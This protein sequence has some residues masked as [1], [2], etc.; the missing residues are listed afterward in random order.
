MKKEL[1]AAGIV[2]DFRFSN[3]AEKEKYLNQLRE[4]KKIYAVLEEVKKPDGTVLIRI[5]EQYNSSPLI[6]LYSY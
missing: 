5:V 2:R 6:E 1:L 4:R 3:S